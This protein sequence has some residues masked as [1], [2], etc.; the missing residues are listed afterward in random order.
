MARQPEPP[1][2]LLYPGE[3]AN[4]FRVDVKTVWR[5]RHTGRIPA[6]QTVT[7]PG[8]RFLYRGAYIRSLLAGGAK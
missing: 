6:E 4:L 5:W 2:E 3:V 1:E 7:T 8:G